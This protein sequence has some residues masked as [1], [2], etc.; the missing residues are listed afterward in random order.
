M[1]I[2]FN[3]INKK[4][5]IEAYGKIG[6]TIMDLA[7]RY[8]ISEIKGVCGGNLSCATCHVVL[9]NHK[10]LWDKSIIE[11]DMLFTLSEPYPLEN[12]RLSC[13]II[14]DKSME[15]LEVMVVN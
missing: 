1:K 9:K 8:N 6:E 10:E 5:K 15:G 3:L 7:K 2:I 13:Q 12:S 14:L 11:E 4:Q